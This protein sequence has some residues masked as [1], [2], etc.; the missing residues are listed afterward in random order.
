MSN[1]DVGVLALGRFLAVERYCQSSQP[2]S[3]HPAGGPHPD[4]GGGH[5]GSPGSSGGSWAPAP[6]RRRGSG[7]GPR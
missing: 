3:T 4:R 5:A 2:S 1:R 6:P 7:W